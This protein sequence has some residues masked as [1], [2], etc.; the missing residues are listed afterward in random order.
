MRVED[1]CARRIEQ[2]GERAEK[3]LAGLSEDNVL[4]DQ[5]ESLWC[6]HN[7]GSLKT[8]LGVSI[9]RL[10]GC[11]FLVITGPISQIYQ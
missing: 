2:C 3:T 1:H 11:Y 10:R 8:S 6:C 4:L 7:S 5:G 9:L